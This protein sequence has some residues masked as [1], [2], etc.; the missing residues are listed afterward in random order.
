MFKPCT[1]P[2]RRAYHEHFQVYPLVLQTVY[3]WTLRVLIK[4]C[5]N[6][7]DILL[8]V[9]VGI[10]A[11]PFTSHHVGQIYLITFDQ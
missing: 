7:L 2:S 1:T 5:E 11:I 3:F 4:Q 10:L 8:K 9:F 6:L